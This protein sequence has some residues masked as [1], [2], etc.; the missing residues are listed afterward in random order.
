MWWWRR[1]RWRPSIGV[2]LAVTYWVRGMTMDFRSSY[3]GR[4]HFRRAGVARPVYGQ[5]AEIR[6]YRRL[7]LEQPR[8][9]EFNVVYLF[10]ILFTGRFQSYKGS[11]SGILL[12]L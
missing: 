11:T 2:M 10:L 12:T 9:A 3:L 6:I 5:S 1:R 7:F 8:E 4:G